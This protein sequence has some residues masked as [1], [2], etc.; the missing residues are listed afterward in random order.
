MPLVLELDRAYAVAKADP[1]FQGELAGYLTHYVG[2]PSPLYFAER[3]TAHLNG[4]KRYFK[5]E[6]WA[7]PARTRSTTAW[8]RSLL[9]P[10]DER[11]PHHRPKPG[12][13]PA[14]RRHRHDLRALRTALRGLHG[15][16]PTIEQQKPN[17]FRMNLLGAEV[18][19][20]TSRD[21][22]LKGRDQT[23]RCATG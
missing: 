14:R 6:G 21:L 17:V 9:T 13:W 19:P 3:L 23:R 10:A 18:R 7:T 4:A 20:M 12:P 8:A 16:E 5:R 2:R 22:T 1:A 15:R 11:D